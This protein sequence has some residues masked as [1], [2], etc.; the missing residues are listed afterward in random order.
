MGL[1]VGVGERRLEQAV[2]Q[3]ELLGG[4]VQLISL[5]MEQVFGGIW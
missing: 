1:A 3:V 2:G 4:W 5:L